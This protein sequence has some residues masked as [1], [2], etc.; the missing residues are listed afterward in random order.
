MRKWIGCA[1]LVC[2]AMATYTLAAERR[3]DDDKLDKKALEVVKQVGE[4]YKNAKSMH[5]EY[6]I[7]FSGDQGG[8]KRDTKLSATCDLE[9][10]NHFAMHTRHADDKDAGLDVVCDGKNMSVCPLKR[11]QYTETAAPADLHDVGIQTLLPLGFPNT[12]MLFVN[13]LGADP[14]DQLMEGVTDCSYAGKVKLDGVEAHHLTFKQPQF[15]WELWVAA[16]GKPFILKFLSGHEED[17]NKFNLVETYRNWK[18]DEAPAKD[19]FT[20][21]APKGAKKVDAL[22]DGEGNDK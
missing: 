19:A 2:V 12:G 17:G 3:G 16:E 10:P 9:Q 6:G 8:E 15:D 5:V 14:Y 20:F 22:S 11:K 13:V 21:S 7:T 18:V 1:A 4:L